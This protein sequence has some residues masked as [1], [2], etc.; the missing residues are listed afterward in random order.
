MNYTQLYD[1]IQ[2]YTENAETTFL[3]N[4]PTFVKQA[5]QRIYNI[6]QFPSLRKSS[7]GVTTTSNRYL[8]CPG[9]FLS[10]YSLAVID[11]SGAYSFLLNKDV[12][13]IR[14]AYPS[15]TSTGI[16]KH[17]ALFGPTVTGVYPWANAQ[18]GVLCGTPL[19]L[20]PRVNRY[21]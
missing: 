10:A 1:A 3:A 21:Y 7:T 16:P 4:I 20:L 19:L 15:P 9:D 8:S 6:V 5:E 12:D 17:Y 13:Y 18:C 2:N 14:Q 11:G